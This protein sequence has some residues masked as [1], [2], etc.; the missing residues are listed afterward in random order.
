MLV[1][2]RERLLVQGDVL[3]CNSEYVMTRPAQALVCLHR[4]LAGGVEEG[5]RAAWVIDRGTGRQDALGSPLRKHLDPSG[6]TGQHANHSSFKVEREL[7]ALLVRGDGWMLMREDGGVERTPDAAFQCAI[8]ACPP[9]HV[10][11]RRAKCIH[12]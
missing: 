6:A 12:G 5:R 1:V 10:L 7:G 4:A 3:A 9:K 2:C 11:G 8:D